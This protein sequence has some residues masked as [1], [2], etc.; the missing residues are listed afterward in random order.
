MNHP[1]KRNVSREEQLEELLNGIKSKFAS[2]PENDPLRV[3]ILTIAP[4]SWSIRKIMDEFQTSYRMAKKGK[5]L[6]MSDGVLSSP[7]TKKG[8]QLP[9]ETILKVINFYED[10]LNSRIMPH[11]KATV[12]IKVNGQKEERQKRLLL[13]DIKVLYSQFK[14]KYENLH[15]GLTKFTELRPK[16][17]VLAGSSGTHTSCVCVI[18][19]NF[20]NMIDALNLGELTKNLKVPLKSKEDCMLFVMCNNPNDKC[21]L[22]TCENCPKI[23]QFKDNLTEILN[24]NFI[25]Q[26]IFSTWTSTDRCTLLRECLSDVDFIDRFTEH[27]LSL[28]PHH[29]LAKFQSK[30][31]AERKENLQNDEVL[32]QLDFAE[33]FA[34][35]AQDAAQAFHYNNDQ[36]TL[37]TIV[38]YYNAGQEI[39]HHSAV[40]LSDSTTHDTAAVYCTQK[41]ILPLIKK[42]CPNVRKIIYMTDGA[43][44]HFKNR[45]QN[46]MMHEADFGVQA[47]WHCHATAHGK[48]APDGIGAIFKREATR[49][50]LQVPATEA[51][52]NHLALYDWASKRFKNISINMYDKVTHTKTQ[53]S[54]Q[55]RFS[56]AQRVPNIQ[57]CHGFIPI[58]SSRLQVMRYSKAKEPMSLIQ[59]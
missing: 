34:Y 7:T 22:K 58:S 27:L 57:Q 9:E 3:S 32:V 35:V 48:G 15:I 37:V 2:L 49:H 36:C 44:Q 14:E 20:K 30:F 50:S 26:V 4:E 53:N 52:L 46:L 24:E 56:S 8:K 13:S 43:K 54:L 17:C 42:I 45:Y 47:E 21:Y 1:T 25:T 19:Q 5:D 33:N 41:I 12:K 11:K 51:I 10:D 38:F 23:D 31:F 29:F 59:Y 39:R 55:K 16:W 40:V 18:C 6:R 28:L